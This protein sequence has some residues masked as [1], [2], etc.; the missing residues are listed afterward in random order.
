MTPLLAIAVWFLLAQVGIQGEQ[1]DISP[2]WY[3]TTISFTVGLITDEVVQ[4]L[5]R[6]TK[7]RL[8]SGT[9]NK[10][11]IK[12]GL[13]KIA[14]NPIGTEELQ[15]I[16][17]SISSNDFSINDAIVKCTVTDSSHHKIKSFKGLTNEQGRYKGSWRISMPGIYNIKLDIQLM[18]MRVLLQQLLKSYNLIISYKK[19]QYPSSVL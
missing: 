19:L 4:V 12:V 13:I 1:A 9:A 11:P 6:F 17:V 16:E 18:I 10:K 2:I 8:G 15:S 7:E 3:F 5:T 14:K